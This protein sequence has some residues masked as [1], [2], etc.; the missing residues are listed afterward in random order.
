MTEYIIE[1]AEASVP[2]TDEHDGTP[3]AAAEAFA[4]DEFAWYESGPKPLTTGRALYDEEALYLFFD[5]TD[6]DIHAEVT[7]LN[8]PTFEDSSVEFFAR[9]APE[10]S[11]HYLNFEANCCG[12]FKL[13]WQAP[14]YAARGLGRDLIPESLAEHIAV[15]TSEEG[16]TREPRSDDESW[17]LA[18]R[19]PFDVLAAFTGLD[20]APSAGTTW[21]G[22]FYRSGL[23]DEQKATWSRIE[24]PE[25]VYH[26]PEYFGR[27][28]FA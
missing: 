22:N 6:R 3:W 9:P 2:L 17:W 25:P 4:L 5:V 10:A 20:V 16:P 12:Q 14:N 8:G 18:A 19:L 23:P 24:E 7:E 26:S 21:T 1:R 11:E 15:E 28:R 13:G 27:L